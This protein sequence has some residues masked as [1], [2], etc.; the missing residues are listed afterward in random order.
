M[1]EDTYFISM[2]GSRC[3][4]EVFRS[5]RVNIGNSNSSKFNFA[6]SLIGLGA[7]CGFGFGLTKKYPAIKNASS[8]LYQNCLRYLFPARS[9]SFAEGALLDE[10]TH[11]KNLA[12]RDSLANRGAVVSAPT[13]LPVASLPTQDPHGLAAPEQ[14]NK[15]L[16]TA[17]EQALTEWVD[18]SSSDAEKAIRLKNRQAISNAKGSNILYLKGDLTQLPSILWQQPFIARLESLQ[19]L[20]CNLASMPKEI[21]SAKNLKFFRIEGSKLS[22]FPA[23]LISQLDKL[24]LFQVQ[25]KEGLIEVDFY[26]DRPILKNPRRGDSLSVTWN[27]QNA[28]YVYKEGGRVAIYA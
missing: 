16:G 7:V 15:D 20:D 4:N 6:I 2:I 28:A 1:I 11:T 13:E 5:N 8:S 17:L 14:L 3:C 24:T 22:E 18:N 21:A 23:H 12:E 25:N 9:S 27:Q 19:L 26:K 10:S